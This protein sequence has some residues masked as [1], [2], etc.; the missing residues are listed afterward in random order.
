MHLFADVAPTS[1]VEMADVERRANSLQSIDS[2]EALKLI[3]RLHASERECEA[4]RLRDRV[5][6]QAMR[7]TLVETRRF[8]EHSMHNP[9]GDFE[10][11]LADFRS[12]ACTTTK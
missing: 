10:A 9:F 2:F 5:R 12:I 3:A 7:R 11:R 6:L 4:L 1:D 8:I